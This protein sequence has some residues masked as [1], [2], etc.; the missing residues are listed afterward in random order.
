LY[1][2]PPPGVDYVSAVP[3]EGS[4]RK[5]FA[6]MAVLGSMGDTCGVKISDQGEA[7]GERR[8]RIEEETTT[9]QTHLL[10]ETKALSVGNCVGEFTVG[11]FCCWG[12]TKNN[13]LTS[14]LIYKSS[15]LLLLFCPSSSFTVEAM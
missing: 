9:L 10:Y 1:T 12:I 3:T 6:V 15:V 14:T 5:A 4:Q 8:K 13:K 2:L 7:K 11:K